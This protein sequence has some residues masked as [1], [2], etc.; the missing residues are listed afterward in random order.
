[1]A[2]QIEGIV[3]ITPCNVIPSHLCLVKYLLHITFTVY[4]ETANTANDSIVLYYV[5]RHI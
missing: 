1:M 5:V 4:F 3:Q 2:H